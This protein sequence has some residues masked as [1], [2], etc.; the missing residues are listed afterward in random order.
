MARRKFKKY[1]I[2]T[3]YGLSISAVA[4]SAI[5][6]GRIMDFSYPNDFSYNYITGAL[7]DDSISVVNI[8]NTAIVK[9]YNVEGVSINKNFYDRNSDETTQ[10]NS[11]IYY[12]NTYMKNTGVMYISEEKFDVVSTLEGTVTS[13]KEDEL[14]GKV[15]EVKHNNNLTTV[16]ECLSEVI[17]KEGDKIIQGQTVG[18]SGTTKIDT[19]IKNALLFEVH[20][21]GELLNPET[22]YTMDVKDLS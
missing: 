8:E 21:K 19:N 15:V 6:F 4:L 9:P 18:Y 2:P 1:V 12:E 7:I 16:Y 17:V 10:Q 20:Y 22:Y 5:L 3:I 11:L 14:L 13:V